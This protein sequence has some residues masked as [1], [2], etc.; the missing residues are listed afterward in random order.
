[1]KTENTSSEIPVDGTINGISFKVIK[2]RQ[3]VGEE[4]KE[5][6]KFQERARAW[7]EKIRQRTIRSLGI[8]LSTC[9]SVRFKH[10]PKRS[11]FEFTF[12]KGDP[13]EWKKR[14]TFQKLQEG[15]GYDLTNQF[16]FMV[17]KEPLKTRRW[18]YDNVFPDFLKLL[19]GGTIERP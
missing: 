8:T 18:F 9:D 7:H 19:H 5:D 11:Y 15:L 3:E 12:D 1:M 17:E 10:C 4:L 6:E 2:G 14:I 16:C 13:T